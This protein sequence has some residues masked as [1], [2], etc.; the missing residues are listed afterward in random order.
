MITSIQDRYKQ[1]MKVSSEGYFFT[2]DFY[3]YNKSWY[4][5]GFMWSDST[6]QENISCL[7]NKHDSEKDYILRHLELYNYTTKCLE[8]AIYFC[9]VVSSEFDTGAWPYSMRAYNDFSQVNSDVIYYWKN[10]FDMETYYGVDGFRFDSCV[11]KNN[12]FYADKYVMKPGYGIGFAGC[13]RLGEDVFIGVKMVIEE[14]EE[15]TDI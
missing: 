15:Y 3:K 1:E 9:T 10:G 11:F 7:L 4:F 5:A 8:P 14:L 12:T 6:T 2:Q 13:G